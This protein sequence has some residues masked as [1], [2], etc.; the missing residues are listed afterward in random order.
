[1]LLE[2]F[3]SLHVVRFCLRSSKGLAA[4]KPGEK[5]VKLHQINVG[6]DNFFSC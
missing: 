4:I 2:T 3:R 6:S 1:M 5:Q